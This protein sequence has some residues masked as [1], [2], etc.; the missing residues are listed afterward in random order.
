MK[1]SLMASCSGIYILSMLYF[2]AIMSIAAL[3]S[4]LFSKKK[5]LCLLKH[6]LNSPYHILVST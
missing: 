4:G 2:W 6:H 3:C 1:I 5:N